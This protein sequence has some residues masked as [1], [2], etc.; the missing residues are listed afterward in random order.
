MD[1]GKA[2]TDLREELEILNAAIAS[3]ERLQHV[4]PRKK[5]TDIRQPARHAAR[6]DGVR[7]LAGKRNSGP[8]GYAGTVQARARPTTRPQG[9]FLPPS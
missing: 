6:R 3:L 7:S 8:P 1:I 4:G 2:L 9:Q 5:T